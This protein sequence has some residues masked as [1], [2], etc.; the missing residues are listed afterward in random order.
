MRND[1]SLLMSLNY[2]LNTTKQVLSSKKKIFLLIFF[3]GASLGT[4]YAVTKK[5][6][7]RALI[8]MFIDDEKSSAG[9][10]GALGIASNFGIDIGMGNSSLFS[11]GNLVELFKSRMIIE[12]ALLEKI[13][14]S[15]IDKTIAQVL[16]EDFNL[17]KTEKDR[18]KIVFPIGIKRSQFGFLQDS[19]S[20]I[21]VNKII[22][23]ES[24]FSVKI[25]DKKLT[26]LNAQFVYHNEVVAKRF[27]ES[28]VQEVTK[29]YSETR[30]KKARINVDILQKQADSVRRELNNAI[31]G[32][33]SENDK[34]YNL[35][36]A[37]YKYKSNSMFKQ[38]DIQT[39]TAILTQLVANLEIAKVSLRKETPLIQIIDNPIYPLKREK[40]SIFLFFI[41]GGVLFSSTVFAYF[42]LREYLNNFKL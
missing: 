11:L 3:F 1:D 39:N 29:F 27:L 15:N 36:P 22:T 13:N 6:Q 14:I 38:V 17:N 32:I 33:T 12:N 4:I 19:L 25:K 42:F 40:P 31:I 20:G 7:Y 9:F 30:S 21:L 2:L 10:S 35:N 8:S 24:I 16:L 23:N 18:S 5:T 26:I 34:T 41:L 28:I 37:L